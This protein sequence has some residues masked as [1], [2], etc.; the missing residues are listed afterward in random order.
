VVVATRP[1]LRIAWALPGLLLAASLCLGCLG[2][3]R[4]TPRAE[5]LREIAA[6]TADP[7]RR[8]S[9]HKAALAEDARIRGELEAARTEAEEALRLDGRNPYAYYVLAEVLSDVGE[10]RAALRAVTESEARFRAEEPGNRAWRRR[11]ER[12]RESLEHDSGDP[13]PGSS[14][15]PSRGMEP[16]GTVW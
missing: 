5:G 10:P 14:E 7:I 13:T 11:A 15:A 1:S 3:L 12:L 6:R 4:P 9:I 2:A 8:A 16:L